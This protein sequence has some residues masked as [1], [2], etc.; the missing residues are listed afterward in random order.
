M[1]EVVTGR[2]WRH[3][4][5]GSTYTEIGRG[6]LQTITAAVME[7]CR[8]VAYIGDDGKLWFRPE[9][10]FEDGR[11]DELPAEPTETAPT[12]AAAE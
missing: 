2:R 5:R 8:L 12:P 3:K 1:S 6:Q 9:T 7:G 4:R 11:F 10:E